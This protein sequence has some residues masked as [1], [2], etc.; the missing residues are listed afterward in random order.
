MGLKAK[1]EAIIYAAEEPITLEQISVLVRDMVLADMVLAEQSSD[2]AR[3]ADTPSESVTE[4]EAL[5]PETT[6]PAEEPNAD[7]VAADV[8]SA[9]VIVVQST[10]SAAEPSVDELS[11]IENASVVAPEQTRGKKKKSD[12]PKKEPTEDARVRARLRAIIEELISDYDREERGIEIRQVAG[13]YRMA[14]KPEH[15]DVVRAFAKSLKPPVR[16]SMA[17]LETLAVIAYKQPVT[18]PEISEIRGVESGGVIGTLLDRK[19]VTTAGRKQVIGRPI[20]YKTS[21]EFL[22]R[23]GL[24]ELAEL[25]SMEEFEKIAAD[26]QGDLFPKQEPTATSIDTPEAAVPALV[27]GAEADADEVRAGAPDA[28]EQSE[29]SGDADLSAEAGETAAVERLTTEQDTEQVEDIQA[30]EPAQP[31]AM[32]GKPDSIGEAQAA[33]AT[34]S[35]A[36]EDEP[37]SEKSKAEEDLKADAVRSE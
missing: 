7:E 3:V 13:G 9:S 36:V 21:K 5:L 31:E 15:H 18:V 26:G 27:P 33:K 10:E 37:T 12:A 2:Q 35:E 8:V 6:S 19:L 17:A 20:L 23:F 32:E 30:A 25:P 4:Q 11:P 16:L 22:L 29:A 28:A 24:N 14:T 34:Q 1:V